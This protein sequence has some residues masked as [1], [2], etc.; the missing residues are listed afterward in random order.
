MPDRVCVPIDPKQ[1]DDFDPQ[2][3]P[4]VETLLSE[5]DQF[6]KKASVDSPLRGK[7][8]TQIYPRRLLV[9]QATQPSSDDDHR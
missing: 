2:T 5:I 1:C 4:T 3:V 8:G 7:K 9:E 6:D